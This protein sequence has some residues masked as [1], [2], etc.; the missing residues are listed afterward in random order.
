MT[1]GTN[2]SKMLTKYISCE[3]KCNYDGRK[4]NSDQKW[5]NDKCHVSSKNIYLK[6]IVF[7]IL[8]H[9]VV[10]IVNVKQVLLTIQ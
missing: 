10:K 9:V 3:C 8:L 5:D 7:G 4:C 2:E 1:T 6:N